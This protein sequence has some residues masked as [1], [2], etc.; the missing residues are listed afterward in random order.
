[1]NIAYLLIGGNIGNR[2]ANLQA[3]TSAITQQCGAVKGFSSI[4]ETAAWGLETQPSFLNQALEIHTLL[5]PQDLL[6]CLLQI[7]KSLGRE[8]GE[9][10]GPRLID[11]DILLYNDAVIEEEGL[12]VPHPQMH[13]RRFVLQPLAEIAGTKLHPVLQQTI[14]QLLQ[15][16][17]DSLSV[18]KFN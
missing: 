15:Q 8:R 11:I 7:E 2:M 16:C 17:P 1:M 13:V 9:K 6:S 3:A 18:H 10:Y 14:S 4:F 5:S 12:T